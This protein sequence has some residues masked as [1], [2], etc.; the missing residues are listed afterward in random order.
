MVGPRR[1]P[2]HVHD[3]VE[4]V[5][6]PSPHLEVST[7]AGYRANLDKHFLPYFGAMPIADVLPSTVQGWVTKAV[8]TACLRA[9]S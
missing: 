1:G 5:W 3:Y 6:W 4:Q 2:G 8:A 9:V 7:R